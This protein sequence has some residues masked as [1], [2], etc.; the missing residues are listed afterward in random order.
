MWKA[1]SQGYR[2][3]SVYAPEDDKVALVRSALE[4]VLCG[5]EGILQ[6]TNYTN[7]KLPFT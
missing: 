3:I 5:W 6:P 1:V 4:E 2:P 7:W